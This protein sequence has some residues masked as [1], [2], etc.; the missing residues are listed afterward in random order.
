[1][2]LVIIPSG[3][4]FDPK[5][6]KIK[7]LKIPANQTQVDVVSL[8]LLFIRELLGTPHF[9]LGFAYEHTANKKL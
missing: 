5:K 7:K 9:I 3:L 2:V 6:I 8:L 4:A 1:M